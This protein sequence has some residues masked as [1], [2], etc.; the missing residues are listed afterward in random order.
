MVCLSQILFPIKKT[1][2]CLKFSNLMNRSFFLNILFL[3]FVN[4]LIK[5]FYIFG[6]D[7]TIQNVVGTDQYGLY[8]TLIN[9]TFLLQIINDFGIQN[10]NSRNISQHRHL[11]HKYFPNIII[12]KLFLTI[13]YS[14][15]TIVLAIVFG[16]KAYLF[17]FLTFMILN[18]VLIS[19]IFFLRSNVAGLGFYKIDSLFSVI[20]RLLLIIICSILLWHPFF[21]G[22]FKIEWLIYAQSTTLF[23]TA[24]IVFLFIRK[25]IHGLKFKFK[26]VFIFLILKRSAPYALLILMMTIYTR[27]DTLMIDQLLPDGKHQNGIYGAGYRLLDA[28]NMLGFLFAGLLL[29]MFARLIKENQGEI[30]SLL[31]FS[32]HTIMSIAIPISISVYFFR[33]EI[34]HLLYVDATAYWGNVL[35]VLILT[36]MMSTTIYIYSTLLTAH[37]SIKKMNQVFVVGIFLNFILNYFL[38]LEH[39][40]LGASIATLITQFVMAIAMI[41]LSKSTFSI[42]FD[43]KL[44]LRFFTFLS[45]VTGSIYYISLQGFDWRLLFFISLLVGGMMAFVTK[46]INFQYLKTFLK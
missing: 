9:F 31:R 26:K 18:Q 35:G 36:F 32:F 22:Q 10:F 27:M 17:P 42:P 40:A 19:M 4:V 12:T 25:H 29:P 5:P 8:V 7:R 11:I 41:G 44:T 23:I 1:Y 3:I 6:I 21:K 20:D 13:S 14:I 34:A 43:L 38:I 45:I 28:V 30:I 37:G 15:I 33:N 2:L 16:Y 39:K 46:M 24:M